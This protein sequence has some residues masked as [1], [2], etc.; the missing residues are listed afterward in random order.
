VTIRIVR[1]GTPRIP[2]GGLRIGTVRRPPR[3]VPAA[4]FSAHNWYD[5]WYPNLAPSVELMKLGKGARTEREWIAFQRKFRSE[6]ARP[7]CSRTLDLLSALSHS[8]DF[9]IGCYCEDESRCHRSV[10]R[11]LLLDRGAKVKWAWTWT[12]QQRF[13]SRMHVMRGNPRKSTVM[14]FTKYQALGNSFWERGACYILGSDSSSCAAAA[15]AKR[16]VLCDSDLTVHMP[17]R[18][19]G[20]DASSGFLCGR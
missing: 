2:S 15:V 16:L 17:G 6:M 18:R 5:I 11:A 4:Q 7:D 9:S 20:I 14:R 10:L 1:L 13:R 8:A 19:L 3:G 12:R